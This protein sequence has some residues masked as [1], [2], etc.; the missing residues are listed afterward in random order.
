MKRQS[1][2]RVD[3]ALQMAGVEEPSKRCGKFSWRWKDLMGKQ[4]KK[5]KEPWPW[6]WT[7]RRPSS[8]SVFLWC[9]P[10]RR[11]SVSE[12][13]SCECCADIL[14]IRGECSSK[15]VWRSRSGPSRPFCQ[16]QS[17]VACLH[18]LCCR[19]HGGYKKLT[20]FEVEGFCG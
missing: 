11:T 15:D 20:S 14:S 5:I 10:G 4:R 6:S 19:M 9:G 7:W 16:G 18:E 12:G 13:R 8:G 17:E 3:W 1:D 2:S